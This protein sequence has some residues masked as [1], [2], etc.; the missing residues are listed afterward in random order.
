MSG[1]D[2]D[3]INGAPQNLM[4]SAYK[5]YTYNTKHEFSYIATVLFAWNSTKVLG[6][7]LDPGLLLPMVQF[8]GVEKC[9]SENASVL[10]NVMMIDDDS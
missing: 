8:L 7:A 10:T 6:H 9:P 4:I 5:I 1:S 2:S 3:L